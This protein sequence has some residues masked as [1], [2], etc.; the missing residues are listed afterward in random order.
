MG[1]LHDLSRWLWRLLPGNPILLRVVSA[2]GKRQRHLWARVIYLA[3]LI[4]V[5]IIM[6]GGLLG[7][8]NSLAE[9]AKDSTQTFMWVSL[10]QL[11]LMSFIAPV[12]CAGA[13]TQE[14]DANTFHILLTTPLTNGQI[15]F[16]TLFSRLFFVWGLLIAGVP[17]FCITM[18]YGGVTSREIFLSLGLAASTGFV[19]GAL[20]IL[21]SFARVGTRRTIFA[22]FL[23][24]ALYLLAIGA[25]GLSPWTW[26][27]AS[28]APPA[29]GA[30][31][32]ISWL[33]PLHPFLALLAV[34]GMTPAPRVAD[35]A[36]LAAP[37][38]WAVA[39]PAYGYIVLT[40]GAALLMIIFSMI[41]VRSGYREGEL[42]FW[43]RIT[44]PFRS[45]TID[46]RRHKPRRVWNNPIA[47]REA[48]TRA[49]AGGRSILR[50]ITIGVGVV[51]GFVLLI[52]HYSGWWGLNPAN[53]A[54]TRS[55]LNVLT[56]IEFGVILLVITNVAAS[57]LTR[58]KESQTIELLLC[59]PL[60]SRYII[61]GMLRG[62]VSFSIP[63][64]AVPTSM[65][66]LF[67]IA[68]VFATA[69]T[70]AVVTVEAVLLA[71]LI[72]VAF[73]SVA[74]MV[75]LQFSLH[76]RTTVRAV[77]LSTAVVMAVAGLL[78]LCG[79]GFAGS[80]SNS[81]V[82]AVVLPFT[83]F[84]ALH[85]IIDYQGALN[86]A[87]AGSTTEQNARILRAIMTV[88]AAGGYLLITYSIYSNMLRGFDMIIRKQ[89]R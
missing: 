62:L 76:S 13:I 31:L 59:S 48:R 6:G 2:A 17:V 87:G 71:P 64:I 73:V 78:T 52:A 36:Q 72:M 19:T 28:I 33:A 75:G 32:R 4:T 30:T 54:N 5:M 38:R 3:A 22:F 89:T 60:T 27:P 70:P 51:I 26:L 53:P 37:I 8:D 57:T 50:W 42:T 74:A 44:S 43:K 21:I 23:G 56:W 47:W 14:K 34:S 46:E 55:W 24:V 16:G 25:L 18:F 45:E 88:I 86:T 63:L 49:S 29:P 82:S 65:L 41:F 61:A 85:A 35:L 80:A 66:L 81:N 12:F 9:L 83:P 67:A 10:V 40:S 11:V 39:N 68:G 58:E 7:G 1:I 79:I 15:V 84:P 77:M 20:A 69:A